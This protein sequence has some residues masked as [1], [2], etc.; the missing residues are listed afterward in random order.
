M[1]LAD[2]LGVFIEQ[3]GWYY[4]ILTRVGG[5]KNENL[6]LPDEM[7]WKEGFKMKIFKLAGLATSRQPHGWK[8]KKDEWDKFL[9]QFELS[10]FID[11]P[12]RSKAVGKHH[13]FL[14]IGGG[15]IHNQP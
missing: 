10:Q 7:G 2:F 12:N 11:V 1:A 13:Y 9:Q 4:P 3:P 14:S 6:Y 15:S 5:C 8:I